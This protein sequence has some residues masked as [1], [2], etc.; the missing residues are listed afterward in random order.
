MALKEMDY[1]HFAEFSLNGDRTFSILKGTSLKEGC[2]E[3]V[4]WLLGTV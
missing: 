1:V 3:R 2:C 4:E